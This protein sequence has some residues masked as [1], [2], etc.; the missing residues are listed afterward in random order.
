MSIRG[1]KFLIYP[2]PKFIITGKQRLKGRIRPSGNKNAALPMLAACLLIDKEVVLDQVPDILDV[3]VM[4]EILADLG[5][6]V[7]F[8]KN[9]VRLC[10]KSLKSCRLN[11]ARG[12]PHRVLVARPGTLQS[13]H[14]S[15]PDIRAGMALIIAA[16]YA[17]GTTTID[18]V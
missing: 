7:E 16:L 6:S 17:K 4:L 14:L 9:K 15:S 12:G 18:N 3:R 11:E 13:G 8:K 2:M 5:G 1:K 10:A